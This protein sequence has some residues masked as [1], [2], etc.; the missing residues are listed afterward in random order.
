VTLSFKISKIIIFL[1]N[2]SISFID[3]CWISSGIVLPSETKFS[4]LLMDLS[5]SN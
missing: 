3:P 4:E 2:E 5:F 1:S